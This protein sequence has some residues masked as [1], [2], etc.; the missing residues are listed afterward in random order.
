MKLT[1]LLNF[2]QQRCDWMLE[3]FL[4]CDVLVAL[5]LGHSQF[6]NVARRQIASPPGRPLEEGRPGIDCLRMR[7][8]FRILSRNSTVNQIIHEGLTPFEVKS[9][10][11]QYCNTNSLRRVYDYQIFRVI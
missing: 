3:Y 10:L 11:I 5:F 4:P 9:E 1:F 2:C 6:I 8:V 7:G